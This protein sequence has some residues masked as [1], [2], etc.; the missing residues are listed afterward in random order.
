VLRRAFSLVAEYLRTGEEETQDFMN[1]GLQLGRRF[2]ALKL[3]MVIRMYGVQGI[4]NVLRRHIDLAQQFADWVRD[5][6]DFELMAPVPFST[7]CFR[8]KPAGI[9]EEDLDHLNETLM[10]SVNKT[11]KMYI[12]HTK[13]RNKWTLR[14]AIGNLKTEQSHVE[15]AWD[16]LRTTLR[17]LNIER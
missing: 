9:A 4:Q 16:L 8:A 10:H 1:Y 5:S 14:L 2:R 11:G 7:V 12:S 13:L 3:W 6:D 17:S 15:Q